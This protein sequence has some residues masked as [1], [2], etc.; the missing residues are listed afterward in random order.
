[1]DSSQQPLLQSEHLPDTT[2][3]K[4]FT[5][6]ASMSPHLA[7]I[8]AATLSAVDQSSGSSGGDIGFEMV[9]AAVPPPPVN[10][11]SLPQ[12]QEAPPPE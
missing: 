1:M 7:F 11:A 10:Q 12:P 5:F 9:E 6:P 2:A 3:G 4:P 8:P